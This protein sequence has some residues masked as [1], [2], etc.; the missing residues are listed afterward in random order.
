VKVFKLASLVMGLLPFFYC[1]Y[2]V[3]ALW[4]GYEGKLGADP[5]K[6]LVRFNGQCALV[7]LLLTQVLTPLKEV[8]GFNLVSIR[9]ILGL[10]CFLYASL[11]FTAYL[12]LLLEFRFSEL[13][14]DLVKRPYI[15]V[16]FAAFILLL[17]LAITSNNWMVARFRGRWKTLHKLVYPALFLALLHLIWL[18]KN[19]YSLTLIYVVI[20]LILL[21]VRAWRSF[22]KT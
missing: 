22:L 9:R 20:G 21:L 17:P 3:V 13:S 16:G 5:G 6:E 11:H 18:T 1:L 4:F 7:F 8:T 19:D 10:F 2:H 14:D 12:L 15:S